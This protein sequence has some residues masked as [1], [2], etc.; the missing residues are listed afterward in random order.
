MAKWSHFGG[1]WWGIPAVSRP[2]AGQ[3]V[4]LTKYLTPLGYNGTNLK[5][6]DDLY[7]MS[8]KAVQ[9]DKSG[10]LTRI[11]YWPIGGGPAGGVWETTARGMCAVDHGIYDARNQPTATDPCN[12]AFLTYLKKL[13]DLYGGY[14][15]ITKFLAGDPD[16]WNGSPK[17]DMASGKAM[18]TPSANAYWSITPFD[19]F[20][21]GVSGGLQYGLTTLPPTKDGSMADAANIPSTQQ[22]IIIPPGAKHPDAAFAAS[23]F[24]AG[25]NGYLLGPSTN[26]SPIAA[27]QECWLTALIAGEAGLRQKAKLPGNPS[28]TLA[29][30]KLQ[31]QLARNSKAYLPINPVEIFY[32]DQ[33]TKATVRVLYGQQ[34][35]ADALAQVQR[36][37]LADEKRLQNQYGSWSW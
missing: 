35:P 1:H 6:F 29:P 28:A 30:L 19:T 20:S 26:G 7:N 25:D 18:I 5:S 4:Y 9:F 24:I 33:L 12:V 31:P 14:G 21:F 27:D 10:N 22:V 23:K 2:Q 8:K 13:T 3:L 36:L 34:S 17:D 32:Q 15:K 37:V 16:I 11:G